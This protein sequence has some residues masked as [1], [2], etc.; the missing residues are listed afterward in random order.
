MAASPA[1][2]GGAGTAL[3]PPAR[4]RPLTA[5]TGGVLTIAAAHGCCRLRREGRDATDCDGVDRCRGPVPVRAP[6]RAAERHPASDLQL[7]TALQDR[8]P[9][10]SGGGPRH[11]LPAHRGRR[12]RLPA[13]AVGAGAAALPG[14][15]PRPG[16]AVRTR[17]ANGRRHGTTRTAWRSRCRTGLPGAA[18]A[19]FRRFCTLQLAALRSLRTLGRELAGG[20]RPVVSRPAASVPAASASADPAP[21]TRHAP[22][23]TRCPT[24]PAP[25]TGCCRWGASWHRTDYGRLPAA[26]AR[27]RAAHRR[28]VL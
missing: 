6:Q 1:R 21:G 25:A 8:S 27:C 2:S 9:G 4:R 20:G 26:G 18:R 23:A 17:T 15:D 19:P 16:H 24:S 11:R 13:G 12:R 10:G 5:R 22:P 14:P 7:Y 28:A 3:V